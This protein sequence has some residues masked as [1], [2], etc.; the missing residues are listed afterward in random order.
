MSS[1]KSEM[2]DRGFLVLTMALGVAVAW[3]RYKV[4]IV[5][6]VVNWRIAV[7]SAIT[8]GVIACLIYLRGKIRAKNKEHESENEIITPIE[9]EDCVFAG[10]S[11][12]TKP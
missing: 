8:A 12:N 10:L 2:S 1:N 4:Q 11:T 9:G 7:S 3:L 6:F 5:T